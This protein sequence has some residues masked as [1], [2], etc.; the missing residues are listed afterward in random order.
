M[1]KGK[2]LAEELIN[3]AKKFRR[4]FLEQT[5]SDLGEVPVSPA[6]GEEVDVSAGEIGDEVYGDA[7]QE[8]VSAM[9]GAGI[10]GF[11]ASGITTFVLKNDG[12]EITFEISTIDSEPVV[13]IYTENGRITVSLA[14]LIGYV[15][16]PEDAVEKIADDRDALSEFSGLVGDVAG[17]EVGGE[18]EDVG[19]EAGDY[20]YG[21]EFSDE[22][23]FEVESEGGDIDSEDSGEGG[24]DELEMGGE[25]EE[26][27]EEEEEV[28]GEGEEDSDKV[29]ESIRRRIRARRLR[30]QADREYDMSTSRRD[31]TVGLLRDSDEKIGGI[32]VK[33]VGSLGIMKSQLD[34]KEG[35]AVTSYPN[36]YALF[37]EK[38]GLPDIEGLVKEEV[39]S[40]SSAK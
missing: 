40:S 29:R 30:E 14:P 36:L 28:A 7:A 26:E 2:T 13:A 20:W 32:P 35:Q 11:E 39:P 33:T 1:R 18:E 8:I 23:G 25:E 31:I 27:E 15:Q 9:N 5:V 4:M 37:R 6:E 3:V 12:K 21:D 10:E 24:S 17:I 38:E 34:G 22:D 16:S 19:V